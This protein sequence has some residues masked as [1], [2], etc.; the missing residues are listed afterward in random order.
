MK[1]RQVF[2]NVIVSPGPQIRP[3][4]RLLGCHPE[5]AYHLR[6]LK[7]GKRFWD[8]VSSDAPSAIT[9]R[10][11]RERMIEAV[12]AGIALASVVEFP[13]PAQDESGSHRLRSTTVAE[14]LEEIKLSKK[15]KTF[16][17]YVTAAWLQRGDLMANDLPMILKLDTDTIV[18]RHG[19]S[20]MIGQPSLSR[21]DALPLCT[22]S[23]A[24]TE[25]DPGAELSGLRFT[26]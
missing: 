24:T 18:R 20:A 13:T 4:N 19:V 10:M 2:T 21:A 25:A 23:G 7:A 26:I 17:A 16:A 1:S 8:N 6:Y 11:K 9:A 3:G 14:Y 15:A 12:A 22:Y 5:G